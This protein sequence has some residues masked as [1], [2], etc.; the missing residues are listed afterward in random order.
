MNSKEAIE[1]IE[2]EISG[3]CTEELID[4][5]Q[6]VS[7]DKL[8]DLKKIITQ[9]DKMIELACNAIS[10]CPH[11]SDGDPIACFKDDT[12]QADCIICWRKYLQSEVSK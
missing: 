5:M 12:V 6:L 7:A 4:Y 1:W 3:C 10:D 9:Q 2:S 11:D 8:Y